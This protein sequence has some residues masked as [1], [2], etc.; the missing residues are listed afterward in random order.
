VPPRHTEEEQADF[1]KALQSVRE[2]GPMPQAEVDSLSM[3]EGSDLARFAEAWRGLPAAARAR[4]I[5]A[6]RGAAEQ[7]LRLDFSA[8]NQLALTDEDARVRLAGIEAALEDRSRALLDE[9]LRLVRDDPNVDVRRAA[10][11]DLARFTLLAEL[12]DLDAES[13]QRLRATLLDLER[14]AGADLLVRN[15]ALA[16]LGYFSDVAIMD[17]LAA[18]FGT[19]PLRVGAVRGMGRSADPRWTDRLMPVLGSE[20]PTLRTEAARALGEI[21]DERAVTPLI[22]V[23]DDPEQE[24]RLAVIAA[25]GRIG[26]DEAR[27]ALLFAA[28]DAQD[29]IREAADRALGE[30]EE[31]E[32]DPLDL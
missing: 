17:E 5:R 10:A 29:V 31:D 27:E 26:G 1:V 3:L 6:L 12:E 15:A 20:D 22:E 19:R 28:E 16:A 4:L 2:E 11:E 24:V 9:L 30:I 13:G 14:D 7:R 21:E 32:A 25:L 8:L 23:I 18:A